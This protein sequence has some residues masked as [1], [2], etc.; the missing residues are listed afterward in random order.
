[1][2]DFESKLTINHISSVDKEVFK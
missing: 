1:M 2:D